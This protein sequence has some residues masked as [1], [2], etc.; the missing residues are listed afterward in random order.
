MSGKRQRPIFWRKKKD[1]SIMYSVCTR[2]HTCNDVRD[3]GTREIG[4]TSKVDCGV[5]ED[6]DR[7]SVSQF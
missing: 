5:T 1:V 2:V 4:C 3:V 7:K 6:K